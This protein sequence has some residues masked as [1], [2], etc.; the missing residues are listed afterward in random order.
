[1]KRTARLLGAVVL[2]LLAAVS[3]QAQE[4]AG[5]IEGVVKDASGMVLPGVSVE[6]RN[7]QG[8]VVSVTT[9]QTGQYRFPSL[10]PGRP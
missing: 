4:Q 1:M 8:A 3:A 6:A 2:L 10:A 5:S 7:A 9:D